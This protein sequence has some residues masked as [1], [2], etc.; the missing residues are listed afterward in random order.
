MQGIE[1]FND[2]PNDLSTLG[3]E[4][5]ESPLKSFDESSMGEESWKVGDEGNQI[6]SQASMP[7]NEEEPNSNLSQGKTID[8]SDILFSFKRKKKKICYCQ[9]VIT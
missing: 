3:E 5:S 8:F 6:L 4:S 1:N 2:W 9:E 7:S